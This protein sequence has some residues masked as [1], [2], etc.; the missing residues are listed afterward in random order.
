MPTPIDILQITITSTGAGQVRKN[1]EEIASG[2]KTLREA[3]K[4]GTAGLGNTVGYIQNLITAINRIPGGASDKLYKVAEAVSKI[5]EAGK[6]GSDVGLSKIAMGLLDVSEAAGNIQ[7]VENL[8]RLADVLERLKNAG[9]V[10]LSLSGV[11]QVS[12]QAA[13][14]VN[15]TVGGGSGTNGGGD[16]GSVADDIEDANEGMEDLTMSA[17]EADKVLASLKSKYFGWIKA[18]GRIALY[19]AIRSIIKG[20]MQSLNDGLEHFYQYSVKVN[21]LYATARAEIKTSLHYVSDALGAAAGQLIEKIYPVVV[22][23]LDATAEI[24]NHI[25]EAIAFMSGEDTYTRAVRGMADINAEAKKLKATILGFD[26]INKLNGN[27]GSGEDEFGHFEEATVNKVR[28]SAT[29]GI[30]AGIGAFFAGSTIASIVKDIGELTSAL[31][32]KGLAG[33][34]REAANA[35][36]SIGSGTSGTGGSGLL[37]VLGKLAAGVG[38]AISLKFGDISFENMLAAEET[39]EKVLEGV[40]AALGGIGAVALGYVAGGIPG[41]IITIGAAIKMAVDDIV[42]NDDA[43]EEVKKTLDDFGNTIPMNA[44]GKH[45]RKDLDDIGEDL[46]RYSEALKGAKNTTDK[47]DAWFNFNADVL[48]HGV[49]TAIDTADAR[50]DDAWNNIK[51]SVTNSDPN[52]TFGKGLQDTADYF[53]IDLLPGNSNVN[54][55]VEVDGQAIAQAVANARPSINRRGVAMAQ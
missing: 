1:L 50:I 52:W 54:V 24:F 8:E 48:S 55:T 11:S 35:F 38:A 2:L 6:G 53:G 25:S 39:D 22:K 46:D 7:N 15:N 16:I 10:K 33:A 49:N 40:K 4:G 23:I 41:V 14:M 45:A 44:Y 3:A 32:A 27:N 30:L 9:F 34:A 17:K 31:G 26:E 42:L 12:Q 18:I 47:V 21:G 19:R 51:N 37:G 36:G 28:A 20:I 43:R 29:T 13:S 5:K